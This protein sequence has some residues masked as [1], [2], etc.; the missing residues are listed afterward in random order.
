VSNLGGFSSSGG[1]LGGFGGSSASGGGAPLK[2]GSSFLGGLAHDVAAVT[3][4]PVEHLASDIGNA[5]IQLPVGLYTLGK[6]IVEH[7]G[8]LPALAE[9]VLKQYENYYGHN[10]L[11]HLYQ[12][13]LQPILDGLTVLDLG[14]TAGV[15]AARV[16]GE[17]GE[18]G[19]VA[20]KIASLGERSRFEVRSP[21]AIGHD[22]LV[23]RGLTPTGPRGPVAERY[24]STRPITKMRQLA[25]NRMTKA[26]DDFAQTH[27]GVRPFENRAYGKAINRTEDI[28]AL[29]RMQASQAY[30][31]LTRGLSNDERAAMTVRSMDI[32]PDV[33]H[34]AVWDGTDNGKQL[35]PEVRQLALNPSKKMVKAEP[36]WRALS[37]SGA[38]LLKERGALSE[39]AELSRPGR[40][41]E[42][43]AEMTGKTPEEIQIHG[44]P[45][46]VPHVT[47]PVKGSH[48][49]NFQGGGRAE[50]KLPGST[51]ANLG[52]LFRSGK[53][54]LHND[55]LGPEFARRVKW[56]KF[57]GIHNG[58]KRGALRMSWDELHAMSG[59][60]RAPKGWG[61]LRASVPQTES[62]RLLSRITRLERI[63]ERRPSPEIADQLKDLYA[64][65]APYVLGEKPDQFIGMEK[66][67]IP[68]S[69]RGEGQHV[70]AMPDPLDLQ[71][72]VVSE[73]GFTTQNIHDAA[74][75]NQGRYFLVP[76]AIS[77]A[78]TG[79]FTRMSDFMYRFGRQPVRIWRSLLLGT[80]PAFLVNNLIGNTLMYLMK[81]G[82]KGAVRDLF[83]AIREMH[84]DRV[85][86]KLLND[87][88]LTAEQRAAL[89]SE[90]YRRYPE[91][92]TAG[93][94]GS[95]QSPSTEG[96][97]RGYH[98][99]AGRAFQTGTSWLPH[100]TSFVA[101]E[102]PR[103]GFIHNF[104]RNSPE[105][106][107]VYRS[108]PRDARKFENAERILHEGKTGVLYQKMISEQVD[109]SIGNYTH[110]SPFE[111]NV[112]RTILP[113]Y[114]WYRAILTT[115]MHL[116][117]D[118]P[119]RA[120]ALFKLGQIGGE[121][122]AGGMQLPSYLAG[123]IPLGG[124]P[125][126]TKRLLYT[127][128]LNPW[129][130]L[131]QLSQGL[132][133]DWTQLGVDPF[134]QGLMQTYQQLANAPGRSG[135]VPVAPGKLITAMLGN[136]IQGLPPMA[137]L[138]PAGPS[139][140]YPNRGR[141]SIPIIGPRES[142]LEAW[143]G[144]PIKEV[145]PQVAAERAAAGQ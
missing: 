18:A 138:F 71:H 30:T 104:I 98:S 100:F 63:Q 126:Q 70:M 79:E 129:A 19:S 45:Y 25:L 86:M 115:T 107:T 5:A 49:M 103:R 121:A 118:N 48:P 47:E 39:E 141:G 109:R 44:N 51:K 2:G 35:T 11:S 31:K 131:G 4:D 105:F 3:I 34:D 92:M 145:N 89:M 77:K 42:Q 133:H 106:K 111:R 38:E 54:D 15:Q 108:L 142:A 16:L 99:K 1:S 65:H 36:V 33:L 26:F 52:E 85:A 123:S 64:R 78:A 72:S 130:T 143:L 59:T 55:V 22:T 57:W 62:G 120:Q 9:G 81:T 93:T 91:Q 95:T 41:K 27:K 21:Q 135:A 113:F 134:V 28:K 40:F 23:E 46:Y 58:L 137:Q 144:A 17:A 114:S 74:V 75:D 69:I 136:I 97:L 94:F 128:S 140:L 53:L 12:H 37:E 14:S 66:Q 76:D 68:Y 29:T 132:T 20:S 124:G 88:A 90:T 50:P 122:A 102:V 112:M 117:L 87:P 13:P 80:R 43:V 96:L 127:Q 139:S 110:L 82:G 125:N 8:Q 84:G 83:S 67:K 73:H 116:A 24:S 119:L 32:N 10:V 6:T 56:L 101:E 7:P 60:G 61:F